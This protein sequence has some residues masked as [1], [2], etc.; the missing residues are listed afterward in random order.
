MGSD[1]AGREFRDRLQE[2]GVGIDGVVDTGERST[3]VKTRALVGHQQIVRID[4]EDSGDMG[5]KAVRLPQ[6]QARTGL[7]GCASIVLEDYDKGVLV[8]EIIQ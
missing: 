2:L 4:R 6:K 7:A 5:P 8:P 1:D 3:T